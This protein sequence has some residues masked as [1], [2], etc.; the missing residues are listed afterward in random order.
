MVK[1][2]FFDIDGT[3]VSFNT[4]KIPDSAVKAVNLLRAKGIRVFIA[5]G[6]HMLSINNLGTLKFDGFVTLNGGCCM[7]GNDQVIYKHSIPRED[8]CSVVQYMKAREDFPCIFL[9]EHTLYMNY[10]NEQ[11]EHIFRMLN[12]PEPPVM[13]LREAAEGEVFQLVAFFT[14]EQEQQIM[15]FMPHCEATRWN[16]LFTDVIPSGSSKQVGMDKMLAYF[17]IALEESMAFG[18]G[19]NDIAMLKHAGIGIAMGNAAPEVKR[20]ADHVTSSV[21]DDGIERALRHFGVI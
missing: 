11:T 8:I 14:R 17:G 10:C 12:F 9:H 21:D 4:H 13:P 3:L 6:R 16:P 18:D 1:A 15:S 5:S 2:V 20:V 19:G 7:V